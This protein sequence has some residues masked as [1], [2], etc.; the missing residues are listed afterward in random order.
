MLRYECVMLRS[1]LALVC[2]VIVMVSQFFRGVSL[3]YLIYL[4]RLLYVGFLVQ[5]I[6]ISR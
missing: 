2:V 4:G 1:L 3:V 6:G 5:V